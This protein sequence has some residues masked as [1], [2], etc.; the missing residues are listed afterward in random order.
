MAFGV[1]PLLI[2]PLH[3]LIVDVD[4]VSILVSILGI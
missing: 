3:T 2:C 4:V 1:V